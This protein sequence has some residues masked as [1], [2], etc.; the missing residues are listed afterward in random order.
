M[1]VQ[2]RTTSLDAVRARVTGSARDGAR[3][4]LIDYYS[5]A[6]GRDFD[7][8]VRDSRIFTLNYVTKNDIAA[9]GHLSVHARPEFEEWLLGEDG[10]RETLALLEQIPSSLRLEE[11]DT[12]EL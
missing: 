5:R 11:V 6:G 2:K 4:H 10:Q 8:A 1:G 7:V 12:A 9:V 3:Q